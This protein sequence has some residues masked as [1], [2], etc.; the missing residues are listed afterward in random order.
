MNIKRALGIGIGVRLGV[1]VIAE[2][3]LNGIFKF[4]YSARTMDTLMTLLLLGEI[5]TCTDLILQKLDRLLGK[6]GDAPSGVAAAEEPGGQ[7]TD[8]ESK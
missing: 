6:T 8:A 2:L 7:T 3:L 1:Y 5:A 4:W